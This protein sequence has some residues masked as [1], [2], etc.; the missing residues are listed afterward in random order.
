MHWNFKSEAPYFVLD[1]EGDG[2]TYFETI[3]ERDSFAQDRID[4]ARDTDGWMEEVEYI[5]A[6]VVTHRATQT[7]RQ[8]RPDDLDENSADS[9]G[10]YWDPDEICRCNYKLLPLSENDQ[11]TIDQERIKAMSIIID[12]W[13][14]E[15]LGYQVVNFGTI[16]N[17]VSEQLFGAEIVLSALGLDKLAQK[18]NEARQST[19]E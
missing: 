9:N 2:I 13:T 14:R 7:E 11:C 3:E 19:R 8:D 16:A 4:Q 12:D 6:G 17:N 18:V 10:D 15:M 5:I 1:P